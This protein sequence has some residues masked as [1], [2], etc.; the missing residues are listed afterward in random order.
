MKPRVK[1]TIIAILVVVVFVSIINLKK[2]EIVKPVTSEL[3]QTT[4]VFP[5]KDGEQ[6]KNIK[7]A[8]KKELPANPYLTKESISALPPQIKE[9]LLLDMKSIKNTE[10]TKQF[11]ELLRSESAID[12]ARKILLDVKLT[13][14]VESEREHFAATR[15]LARALGDLNNKTNNGLIEIVKKIILKENL[16]SDLPEK[17]KMILAGDKAELV[18]TLIAFNKNAHKELLSRTS[19]SNIKKIVENANNYNESMRVGN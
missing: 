7:D 13:D 10:E 3:S 2:V 9:F 8:N 14:L 16:S 15:F 6:E 17:A 4:P 1:Y 5:A 18:Q 12:E 19:N 11:Y